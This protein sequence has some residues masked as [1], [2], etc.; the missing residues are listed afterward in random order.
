MHI[1]VGDEF[2]VRGQEHA[3]LEFYVAFFDCAMQLEAHR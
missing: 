1:R 2:F 3:P